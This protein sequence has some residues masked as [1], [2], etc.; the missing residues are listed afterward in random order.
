[1]DFSGPDAADFANVRALNHAFLARLRA[2][3]EGESLRQQLPPGISVL[4]KAL[5]NLQVD[6]LIHL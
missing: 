2:P 4:I 6:I 5:T 1:M 3:N